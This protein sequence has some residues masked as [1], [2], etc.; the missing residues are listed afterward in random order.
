[1]PL[2]SWAVSDGNG[3][4][5]GRFMM[6]PFHNHINDAGMFSIIDAL[7][8]NI[9]LRSLRLNKCNVSDEG[10]SRLAVDIQSGKVRCRV[11]FS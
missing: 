11:G 6:S 9:G 10:A 4:V 1:M 8:D 7:H 5:D 3:C 2:C